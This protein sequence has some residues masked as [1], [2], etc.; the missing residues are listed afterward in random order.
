MIACLGY[1]QTGL[2]GKKA[3]DLLRKTLRGVD[4]GANRGAAK[5]NLSRASNRAFDPLDAIANLCG[6]ATELLA[7]G[8]GGC[9]HQVRAA[10][11]DHGLPERGLHLERL[12]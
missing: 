3:N 10:G 4:A 5:R 8:N 1:R 6:I 2:C 9:I 7:E 11:L 12:G